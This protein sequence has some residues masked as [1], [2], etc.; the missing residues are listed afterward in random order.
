MQ[1][2]ADAT[3]HQVE[4]GEKIQGG[5]ILPEVVR[6]ALITIVLEAGDLDAE[7]AAAVVRQAAVD[8]GDDTR[9]EERRALPIVLVHDLGHDDFLGLSENAE[10]SINYFV[11]MMILNSMIVNP[12]SSHQLFRVV[13][14][15]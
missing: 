15:C 3:G 2:V 12:E 13:C 9:M 11:G 1:N 5:K 10:M 4:A 7:L 8:F 14:R 6:R